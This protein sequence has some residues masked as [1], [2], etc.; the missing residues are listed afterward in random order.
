[1]GSV[2]EFDWPAGRNAYVTL[3]LECD[4]GTA[5]SENTYEAVKHID[6]LVELLERLDVPLTCFVQT[7]LLEVQPAT[8]ERLREA[9]TNV[10]FHPHSHLHKPRDEISVKC[11]IS[12]SKR[13]YQ[14]FFGT[15]PSGYRFP[16]GDVRP[17]DQQ[18]LANHGYEFDASVFPTWRPG[19]F[20]NLREPTRPSYRDDIDLF[21]IP[22]TVYSSLIKVPTSLSYCQILGRPYIEVIKRYPPSV[23][24]FNLHM[25]D[26]VTPST[27]SR[28]P[29]IYRALYSR[30]G[31]GLSTLKGIVTALQKKKYQ[32]ETLDTV[33]ERLRTG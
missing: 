13:R 4:Y 19:V 22:N 11:E 8:V 23:L 14:K 28:L 17:S 33:H 26:L 18:V 1:M 24:V 9:E 27:F 30:V 3:D 20:N 12:K 10:T 16:N 2:V 31:D 29:R 15:V 7:E 21:E 25:H 5:L 6:S 32:F